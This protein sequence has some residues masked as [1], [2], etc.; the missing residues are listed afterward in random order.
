MCLENYISLSRGFT[1]ESTTIQG[2]KKQLLKF[3]L[4][5]GIRIILIINNKMKQTCPG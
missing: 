5:L 1:N 3:L 4:R 2:F